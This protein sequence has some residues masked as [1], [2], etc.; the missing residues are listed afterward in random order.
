MTKFLKLEKQSNFMAEPL[1]TNPSNSKE[2]DDNMIEPEAS[3]EYTPHVPYDVRTEGPLTYF[4]YYFEEVDSTLPNRAEAVH[5]HSAKFS[6]N[7]YLVGAGVLTAAALSGFAIA[8][9]NKPEVSTKPNLP[10]PTVQQNSSKA[11]DSIKRLNLIGME[12]KPLQS[13]QP[14]W[15]NQ[16]SPTVKKASGNKL[17]VDATATQRSLKLK[18]EPPKRLAADQSKALATSSLSTL[19]QPLRLRPLTLPEATGRMSIA[20]KPEPVTKLNQDGLQSKTAV[21]TPQPIKPQPLS[22]PQSFS[23]A[24]LSTETKG[25]P[26]A[27]AAGI[28]SP[29]TLAPQASAE[30]TRT[31]SPPPLPAQISLPLPS[32]PTQPMTQGDHRLETFLPK[33]AEKD[34]QDASNPA[35]SERNVGDESLG[36]LNAHSTLPQSIQDLLNRSRSL[37]ADKV[38]TL[39]PLTLKAAEDV[40]AMNKVGLATNKAERFTILHL[41]LQDYQ[42]AWL[43]RNTATHQPLTLTQ[44]FPA[45]GFV[46][47]QN[48]TIAV[49]D[50]RQPLPA[51]LKVGMLAPAK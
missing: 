19:S 49:L 7:R 42:Q 28:S 5:N 8:D 16:P 41:N 4:H 21:P 2:V 30:P 23:R 35:V 36:A 33:Q 12:V 38:A 27:Q 24:R 43:A 17:A 22:N 1:N 14:L 32:L 18:E 45:Y 13:N 3:L 46:D 9:I 15:S 25:N 10:E 29:E 51:S 47:D 34:V 50:Q 31:Q 48:R 11:T 44:A 26:S 6:P 20:Q 40:L 39:F 37:P